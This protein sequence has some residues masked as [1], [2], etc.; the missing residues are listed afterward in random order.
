MLESVNPDL[1]AHQGS[2]TKHPEHRLAT[3]T[4]A[5]ELRIPFTSG[6][7]VGI[8]ESEQDRMDSLAALAEVQARHGHIQE[9]ILQN[10]VPHPKYYG[11]EVADIADRATAGRWGRG[12]GHAPGSPLRHPASCAIQRSLM[13]RAVHA[14]V[15]LLVERLSASLR[16]R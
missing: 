15:C 5:Q 4:A 10:Y 14:S 2:P 12:T 8:G 16:C 7:L 3:L 6:I 13:R 9:L 11:R 1:V